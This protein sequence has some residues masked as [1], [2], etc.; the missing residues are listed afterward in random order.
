MLS[1][2]L[3]RRATSPSDSRVFARNRRSS[4]NTEGV[5]WCLEACCRQQVCSFSARGQRS[6]GGQAAV[7]EKSGGAA[8]QVNVMQIEAS[9]PSDAAEASEPAARSTG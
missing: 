1:G 8:E 5:P 7:G 3:K 9:W 6:A 4:F 2:V